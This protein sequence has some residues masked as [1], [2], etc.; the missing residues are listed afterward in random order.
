M[1]TYEYISIFDITKKVRHRGVCKF[2]SPEETEEKILSSLQ[3]GISFRNKHIQISYQLYENFILGVK[4]YQFY[5]ICPKCKRHI[6]KLYIKNKDG[7]STCGCRRCLS[8]RFTR[9]TDKIQN[10]HYHINKLLTHSSKKQRELSKT[11]IAKHI[12]D[13]VS[14]DS[15]RNAYFSLILKGFE[16]SIINK[17]LDKSATKEVKVFAKELMAHLRDIKKIIFYK[18]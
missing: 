10:L 15:L 11:A 13:T 1:I 17:L 12:N 9:S 4:S 7:K 5:F 2:L 3:D 16:K 14:N 6:R 18:G 8:V